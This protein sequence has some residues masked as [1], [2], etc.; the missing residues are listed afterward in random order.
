M[1]IGCLGG[2]PFTVSSERIL[3]P[4]N[5]V[6]S[7]S[8]TYAVHQRHMGNALT[9]YVGTDPDSI[10]F[11]LEISAWMGVDPQSQINVLWG[12]IRG[13]QPVSLVIGNIVYGKY[14]WV[15]KSFKIKMLHTDKDGTWQAV[16]VSV[17]LQ[18]YIR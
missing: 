11:D 5:F 10:T 4:S 2:I 16:T 14:R 9:E 18:E 6:E 15:I 3:T 12:Y 17:S 7:A 13:A 8:A 1:N